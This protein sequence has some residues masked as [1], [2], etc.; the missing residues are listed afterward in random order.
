MKINKR[1]K[2]FFVG[3]I[4]LLLAAFVLKFSPTMIGKVGRSL[5]MLF[6]SSPFFVYATTGGDLNSFNL[7]SQALAEAA[8][9]AAGE[10]Q[11]AVQDQGAPNFGGGGSAIAF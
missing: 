7:G 9:D 1:F 2:S 3:T 11:G 10:A 8:A 6:A 4:F 5:L